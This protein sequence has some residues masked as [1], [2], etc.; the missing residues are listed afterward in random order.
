MSTYYSAG[1]PG[2]DCAGG[3]SVK[4]AT[5]AYRGVMGEVIEQPVA[6]RLP[7]AVAPDQITRR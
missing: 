4:V 7:A 2:Y 6:E 5:P 3:R 1:K